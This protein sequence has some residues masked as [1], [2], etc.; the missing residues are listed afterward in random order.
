MNF[1]H[2][3]TPVMTSYA[4]KGIQEMVEFVDSCLSTELK[5]GST[6][7][8]LC[9]NCK[10]GILSF[11]DHQYLCYLRHKEG[12]K[13]FMDSFATC[14]HCGLQSS[15]NHIALQKVLPSID[16]NNFTD[17]Q[18]AA[19]VSYHILANTLPSSCSTPTTSSNDAVALVNYKYNHHM[20]QHTRT[21]FKKF[22]NVEWTFLIY[23]N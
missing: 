10:Q 7:D 20:A 14:N 12:C 13:N 11:P 16:F 5:P 1:W 6:N 18:M 21:C 8:L 9:F 23:H 2:G 4:K 22:L 19:H 3:S 15:P 17:S